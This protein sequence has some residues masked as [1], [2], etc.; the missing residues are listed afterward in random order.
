MT[1]ILLRLREERHRQERRQELAWRL[2][3]LGFWSIEVALGA[4]SGILIGAL[5][6]DWISPG[7]P[8]FLAIQAWL[9][10]LLFG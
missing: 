7:H 2:F 5:L 1:R 4:A 8:I 10:N 3:V 6:L 9:R